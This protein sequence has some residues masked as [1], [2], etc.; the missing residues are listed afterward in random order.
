VRPPDTRPRHRWL[1]SVASCACPLIAAACASGHAGNPPPSAVFTVVNDTVSTVSIA[2]CHSRIRDC[3][4]GSPAHLPP[5]GQLS[6]PL[7]STRPAAPNLL[8]ITGYGPR[9]RCLTVPAKPGRADVTQATTRACSA[10]T[11]SR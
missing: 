4:N 2:E 3:I 10:T 8:V 9:T 1:A 11:A 5:R 7:S 6:S